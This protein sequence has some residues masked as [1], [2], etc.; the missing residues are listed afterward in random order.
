MVHK[1]KYKEFGSSTIKANKHLDILSFSVRTQEFIVP[2]IF[3][4]KFGW[5][6]TGLSNIS[7]INIAM[8]NEWAITLQKYKRPREKLL[9][10]PLVGK[11]LKDKCMG[12]LAIVISFSPLF[13]KHL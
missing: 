12:H 1:E 2:C 7:S 5:I 3:L 9:W 10:C 6:K 4:Y 13:L 8:L 11:K